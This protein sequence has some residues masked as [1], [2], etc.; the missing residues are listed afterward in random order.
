MA[1]TKRYRDLLTTS[2]A[3]KFFGVAWIG[4]VGI[5]MTTLS[6]VW[7]VHDARGSFA[8]AGVVTGCFAFAEAVVGPQVAR[9]VDAFGQSRIVPLQSLLHAAIVV[10]LC[11]SAYSDMP[12]LVLCVAAIAAGAT[13]PQFGALSATRWAYI[14]RD[15]PK[16]NLTAAFSLE[17]IANSLAF[18]AGP[19]LV[20]ALGA[21]G[22]SLAAQLGAACCILFAGV[23][24]S[25]LRQTDPGSASLSKNTVNN[26]VNARKRFPIAIIAIIAMNLSIGIF[27]GSNQ[28]AVTGF[29][30]SVGSPELA[31]V[32]FLCASLAG[33]TGAM[34]YGRIA[35]AQPAHVRLVRVSLALSLTSLALPFVPSVA[36]L[37]PVIVLCELFVPPT[38]VNLNVLMESHASR[39]KLTQAFTWANS[40]SAAGAA[41]ASASAGALVDYQGPS[42]GFFVLATGTTL[43]FA[44][45]LALWART[46][47][48]TNRLEQS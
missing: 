41:I 32:V 18:M 2:R 5:A 39:R 22:L 23:L 45:S 37:I 6:L 43:V 24:L 11:I 10:L 17:S 8:I 48:Q 15:E 27:F 9:L 30:I 12:S 31:P 35:S 25:M 38:L 3:W 16:T 19:V 14:L 46:S 33:L 21:Q 28:V 29:T 13:I 4:R 26:P 36:I 20:S 40:A 34:V 47:H 44:I 7:M 42:G 1:P